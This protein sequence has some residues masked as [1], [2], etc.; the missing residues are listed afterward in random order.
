MKILVTLIIFFN[1]FSTGLSQAIKAEVFAVHDGDSYKVR[2]EGQSKKTW[3]RLRGVD[4]PEVYSPYTLGTQPYGKQAGDS[5]RAFIKHK[6]LDIE[7]IGKDIYNREIIK[8]SLD[9]IDLTLYII[10]KG[11]GWNSFD[12]LMTPEYKT[13]LIDARFNAENNKLGLWGI[14]GAKLNPSDWRRTHKI[15][16]P[17]PLED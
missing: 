11:W 2:V 9:T 7:V 8:A 10:E 15:K 4:C 12:S 6:I 16:P 1:Y 14:P 5:V 17:N 13:L 3:V